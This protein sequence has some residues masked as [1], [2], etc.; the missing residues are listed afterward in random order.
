MALGS[1]H[2]GGNSRARRLSYYHSVSEGERSALERRTAWLNG[3]DSGIEGH[4]DERGGYYYVENELV[5]VAEDL[6]RVQEALKGLGITLEHDDAGKL[7]V[8]RT[9]LDFGQNQRLAVPDVLARVRAAE[10][11]R[12]DAAGRKQPPLRVGPNHYLSG[13]PEYEGGPSGPAKPTQPEYEGGPS[14]PAQP[15][16]GGAINLESILHRLGLGNGK[17]VRVTV[18]D[19]GYTRGPHPEMDQHVT[20]TGTPALD[21]QPKDGQIDYEAGHGTFVTWLVHRAAPLAHVDVVEALG[22]AGYGTE[23]DIAQAILDHADSDVINLSLGGYTDGD[24]A[25]WS[26]DAALQKV[27]PKTAIVAAAGNNGASRPMWPAAFKR[28]VAVGAVGHDGRRAEF[29]NFGWWVD[30]CTGGVDIFGAFPRY[31]D[32]PDPQAVPPFF[33]GWAIWNGT[34]FAAP[35]VA[36]EIAARLSTRRYRTARSAA[37]SLVNDAGRPHLPGLGTLLDL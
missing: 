7:G 35:K 16:G 23:H 4:D 26:L 12:N 11:E 30:V 8:V 34:S 33:D 36:G 9:R 13:E 24:H 1:A 27:S 21:A 22:P 17:G 14:G 2:R 29:S 25:P 6:Q 32:P 15:T 18:I 31:P 3:P 28:V 37:S 10:Q 19:T 20:S 5:V